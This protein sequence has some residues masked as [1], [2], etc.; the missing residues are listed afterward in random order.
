MKASESTATSDFPAAWRELASREGDGL[1]VGLFWCK[2]TNRV[3]VTVDD[4]RADETFELD[5]ENAEAL[6]AFYH[7]FAY[8]ACQRLA[9]HATSAQSIDLQPQH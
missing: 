3:R 7:P 6:A 4:A 9:G 5:V 2:A 1:T 8:A